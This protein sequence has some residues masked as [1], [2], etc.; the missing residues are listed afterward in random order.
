MGQGPP[1][2]N[3]VDCVG[4]RCSPKENQD[5]C[6]EEENPGGMNAEL[7]I[8]KRSP[9]PSTPFSLSL[10]S[11]YLST[12]DDKRKEKSVLVRIGQ[13]PGTHSRQVCVPPCSPWNLGMIWR[14]SRQLDAHFRPSPV[15]D[16]CLCLEQVLLISS[17]RPSPQV[18]SSL[19]IGTPVLLPSLQLLK[20]RTSCS[21][22][23]QS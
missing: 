21:I 3:P 19:P 14:C 11:L 22:F 10:A 5:L 20:N 7:A 2:G 1:Q 16:V 13:G 6:L 18:K 8:Y 4:E 15:W 17:Q 12:T 9:C 23:E